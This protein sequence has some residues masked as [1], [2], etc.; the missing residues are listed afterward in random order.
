MDEMHDQTHSS[1]P[2]SQI[3]KS[4]KSQME[5]EVARRPE[6]DEMHDQ[7]HSNGGS[8]P[9]AWKQNVAKA[10]KSQVEAEVARP[11]GDMPHDQTHSSDSSGTSS[12]CQTA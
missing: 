7:T 1:S 5:A 2:R 9:Q 4:L 11:Q 6:T 3:A 10:F 12:H 8:S